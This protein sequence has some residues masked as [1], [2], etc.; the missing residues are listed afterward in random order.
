LFSFLVNFILLFEFL[1]LKLFFERAAENQIRCAARLQDFLL[2]LILFNM[3]IIH[4]KFKFYKQK[5]NN[6]YKS[7]AK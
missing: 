4:K 3:L 2:I 1:E 7:F 5:V 6:R